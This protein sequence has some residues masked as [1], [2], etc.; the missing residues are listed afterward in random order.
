MGEVI[1]K[2]YEMSL[3]IASETAAVSDPALAVLM[4][5][6]NGSLPPFSLM[7]IKALPAGVSTLYVLPVNDLGR[8]FFGS[9]KNVG[10][11][12]GLLVALS[13]GVAAVEAAGASFFSAVALVSN[14]TISREPVT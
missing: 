7:V 14:T 13:G 1:R 9:W 5:A 6:S 2:I 12:S 8:G 11:G 4:N 10:A 3:P